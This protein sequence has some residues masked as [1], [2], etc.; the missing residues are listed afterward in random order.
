MRAAHDTPSLRTR[1]VSHVWLKALVTPLFMVVFFIIYFAV[2]RHPGS[3][4]V[5]IP[6]TALDHWISFQPLALIPYASLWLYVILPTA[7]MVSF[8]E[9]IGY[10]IGAAALSATGLVIFYV[11]PTITPPADIDW[12]AHPSIQFLKN[13]D[14]SGNACPSLHVAFAV[15]TAVWLGRMLRRLGAGRSLHVLN[16][17]WAVAILYSTLATRQHVAIDMIAGTFL[18]GFAAWLNLRLCPEPVES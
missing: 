2:L 15:F 7:L 9:L 8:R 13:M 12:T 1:I 3:T 5:E 4:P 17:I 6:R 10:T 18:G 16:V 11:W 14:A